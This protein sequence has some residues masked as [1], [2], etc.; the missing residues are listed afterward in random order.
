MSPATSR[1][2]SYEIL[3]AVTLLYR[4][5]WQTLTKWF[6]CRIRSN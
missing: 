1:L 5:L 2:T 3:G 4:R 6:L